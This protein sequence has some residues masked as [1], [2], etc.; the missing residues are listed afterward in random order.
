M[1]PSLIPARRA[2]QS[3]YLCSA[4][5]LGTIIEEHQPRKERCR[6]PKSSR[7]MAPIIAVSSSYFFFPAPYC[8]VDRRDRSPLCACLQLVLNRHIS[9]LGGEATA[10]GD[11]WWIAQHDPGTFCTD[12]TSQSLREGPGAI[13]AIAVRTG[14]VGSRGYFESCIPCSRLPYSIFS[15]SCDFRSSHSIRSTPYSVQ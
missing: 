15:L 11:Y 12:C 13:S 9:Q 2:V 5:I 10:S 7:V 14:V 1:S 8:F 6:E 3:F 4:R